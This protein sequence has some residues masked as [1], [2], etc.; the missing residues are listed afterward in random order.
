MLSSI[1]PL[2]ERARQ[3]R[4]SA[5][6]TAHIVG[7]AVGGAAFGLLFAGLG[8][9]LRATGV[10]ETARA[11]LVLAVAAAAALVDWR[12]WPRWLWRPHRQVDENW[13]NA[14]RGWVYGGGWGVQLGFGLSTI[15]TAATVYVIAAVAIAT[16]GLI[17]GLALGAAFGLARGATVLAGRSIDTPESLMSFHRRL[18]ERR[19]WGVTA[20]VTGDTVTALAALAIVAGWR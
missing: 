14:Y 20:A 17:T 13:I 18:Q 1:H 6:V 5:T 12:G 2:G 16:A 7:S 11:S 3:N 9:A 10:G 19:R 15:V 8:L 4:W